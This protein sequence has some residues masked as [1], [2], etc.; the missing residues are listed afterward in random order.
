VTQDDRRASLF[1]I[2]KTSPGCRGMFRPR[3]DQQKVAHADHMRC[4]IR[5]PMQIERGKRVSC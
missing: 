3:R 2:A 1:S 4:R 5:D